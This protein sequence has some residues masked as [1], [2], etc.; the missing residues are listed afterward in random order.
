MECKIRLFQAGLKAI[1]LARR[2]SMPPDIFA[3]LLD[4]Y[5]KPNV[6]HNT[7]YTMSHIYSGTHY[8][9]GG[10]V[11]RRESVR[12]PPEAPSVAI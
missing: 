6:A 3:S 4:F 10:A 12:G 7:T 5:R 11:S 8:H 1:D 2:P 9:G